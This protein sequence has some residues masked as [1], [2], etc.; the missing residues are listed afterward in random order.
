MADVDKGQ[1]PVAEDGVRR[2]LLTH[3][4]YEILQ[5][6]PVPMHSSEVLSRVD[7]LVDFNDLESSKNASGQVRWRMAATRALSW[8]TFV[9]G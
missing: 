3:T 8:S 2:G 9:G 4:I 7:E 1:E 5:Q 6:S